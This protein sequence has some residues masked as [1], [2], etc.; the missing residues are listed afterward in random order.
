MKPLNE[1]LNPVVC[2]LCRPSRIMDSGFGET[3]EEA[4]MK[5]EQLRYL[6]DIEQTKSIS[7]TGSHFYISPQ[8][9]SK[10]MQQLESEVGVTLLVRSPFGVTLTDDGKRFLDEM[11]PF[12]DK[13]DSLKKEFQKE[14][15]KTAAPECLPEIRIGLSSV[16]AGVLLPK[17]IAKFK[18]TYPKQPISIEEISYDEVFP[19]L[20]EDRFDLAFLS[21][22]SKMFDQAWNISGKNNLHYRLLLSDKLVACV[23]SSSPL[24]KKEQMSLDDLMSANR[25]SLGLTYTPRAFAI[26]ESYGFSTSDANMYSGNNID[27]HR[28]SMKQFDAVTV[29]P[30]FVFQKAFNGKGFVAKYVTDMDF[31]MHHAAIYSTTDPHPQLMELTNI[32][33][34]LI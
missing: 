6:R 17:A 33:A 3:G 30:R 22:N 27:F 25:T 13:Y 15:A 24:A 10:N 1:M 4:P 16:L 31:E 28:E 32:L 7:K 18:Q 12:I 8:A 29:M 21:L 11:R 19:S 26:M 5:L 23:S 34:S 14:Q 20:R 2:A 9:L